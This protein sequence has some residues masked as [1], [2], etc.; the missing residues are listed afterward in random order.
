MAVLNPTFAPLLS[1]SHPIL[2]GSITLSTDQLNF[3]MPSG[4]SYSYRGQLIIEAVPNGTV[5]TFTANVLAALDGKS[6][7]TFNNVPG[8]SA[9][10]FQTTPLQ[11]LDMSGFG[12]IDVQFAV[13]TLV[14]GTATKIDIWITC[15]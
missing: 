10:N 9:L 14:L 7:P 11:R 3:T 8:G 12:A 13:A 6:G 2:V 5:T 1:R 15:G 4:D